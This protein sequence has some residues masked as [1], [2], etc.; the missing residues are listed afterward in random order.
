MIIFLCLIFAGEIVINLSR[1]TEQT[2]RPYIMLSITK[3][4]L[5]VALMEYGPAVQLSVAQALLTDKQ[6]HSNTGQY[7]ELFTS[8]G[9]LFNLLYRKVCCPS[10]LYKRYC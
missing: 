3:V 10:H 5:D 7:L 9:E 8:S 1:S 4:C 6:H 2:E